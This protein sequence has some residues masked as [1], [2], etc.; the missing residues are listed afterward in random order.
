MSWSS[1]STFLLAIDVVNIF[2][3]ARSVYHDISL[4]FYFHFSDS[5]DIDN[6]HLL[7]FHLYILFVEMS[8][9]IFCPL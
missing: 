7:I 6:Y 2:F 9:N 8:V 3:F 1:F 5:Y 4:W